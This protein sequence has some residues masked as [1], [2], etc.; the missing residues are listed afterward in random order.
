MAIGLAFG[1]QPANNDTRNKV[2]EKETLKPIP[3]TEITARA[4]ETVAN[5][6]KIVSDAEPKSSILSMEEDIQLA[7]DS[8]KI[9]RTN[10]VLE[11][12]AELNLRVLQ[13]LYQEWNL[14]FKQLEAWKQTLQSRTLE[15]EALDSKL[16]EL[17]DI[18]KLTSE[19]AKTDKAPRAIRERVTSIIQGINEAEKQTSKRLNNLLILQNQISKDQLKINELLA[20]IKANE[21]ETRKKLFVID[22]PPLWEAFQ[23]DRDSLEFAV[24][25]K[26]SWAELLRSNI[27][28]VN[29][30]E[31]RFYFHL[32]IYVILIVLM[33]YLHQQNKRRNL[34]DDEDE[35]LKASAYF[36][37]RPF[38]AAL[39]I[40]L[41]LSIWIYPEG[42]SAV[43]EFI[44][45]LFL[46]PVIR[47]LPGMSTKE[48]RNPIFVLFFLFVLDLIQRN[49]IGFVLFNE[50][51]Y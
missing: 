2:K 40:T 46:I 19:L 32:A 18:W 35:K 33:L 30:N 44:L 17:K 9:L 23:A 12:L 15:L 8:L 10:P 29:V 21:A 27:A 34:I 13:N 31:D 4:D 22:S 50:S 45:L 11:K 37:S 28:F 26:D 49:A 6:T 25:F 42:T 43:T 24:Q 14:Y 36:I 51:C 47:L 38:S 16:K 20:S 5:L 48:I 41:I 1:Q 39:L 3:I 7:L